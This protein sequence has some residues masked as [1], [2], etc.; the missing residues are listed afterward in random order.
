[1]PANRVARSPRAALPAPPAVAPAP[2]AF[3]RR[4]AARANAHARRP[5]HGPVAQLPDVPP[6]AARHR[7]PP[8]P[9]PAHRQGLAPGSCPRA[10]R[11]RSPLRP[12]QLADMAGGGTVGGA[13]ATAQIT[14]IDILDRIHQAIADPRHIVLRRLFNLADRQG[15]PEQTEAGITVDVIG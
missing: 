13:E 12:Q 14:A 5:P 7:A 6:P 8:A 15:L 1:M 2:A 3:R 4:N 10:S 11:E 9:R